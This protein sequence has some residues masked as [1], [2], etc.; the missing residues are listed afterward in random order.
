M[1]KTF[2]QTDASTGSK[3]ITEIGK[4]GSVKVTQTPST[5]FNPTSTSS[6]SS[7]STMHDSTTTHNG[8]VVNH[9]HNETHSVSG[10]IAQHADQQG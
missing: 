3:Q 2:E 9:E 6:N 8:Q 1:A 4:D 10:D 5:N 7:T